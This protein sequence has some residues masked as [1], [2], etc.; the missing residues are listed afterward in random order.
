MISPEEKHSE[1]NKN[2]TS[3]DQTKCFI[4][5]RDN[6]VDTLQTSTNVQRYKNLVENLRDILLYVATLKNLVPCPFAMDHAH[7]TR[8]LAVHIMEM[9]PSRVPGVY[10]EFKEGK[11]VVR[12][13]SS[14]F[15]TLGTDQTHEQ[16][17][18]LVKEEGV[19]TG[20]FD[21]ETALVRWMVAGPKVAQVVHEFEVN[22]VYRKKDSSTR[23]HGQS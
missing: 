11:Y 8:W 6:E 21:N 2:S 13:T 10:T 9:L 3:T 1:P 7:Y 23:Q 12:K 5:Q 14:K 16:N 18:A 19:A 15:S 4:C 20:L 22:E 17:N